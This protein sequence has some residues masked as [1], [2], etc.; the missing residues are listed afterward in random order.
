MGDERWRPLSVRRGIAEPDD[1][2]FEGVPDHLRGPLTAW[3][4][5]AI[6][7]WDTLPIEVAMRL[8]FSISTHDGETAADE[9][10]A[11]AAGNPDLFFDAV[12]ALLSIS[13][14][15]PGDGLADDTIQYLD[16]ILREGGSVWQVSPDQGALIQRVNPAVI[17]AVASVMS[18]AG[19]A[20]QH[21]AAAWRAAYGRH[22]DPPRAYSE[23][24]LA[25]EAAGGHLVLPRDSAATLGKM[26]NHIR[27]ALGRWHIGISLPADGGPDAA[28][29]LAM[30][31]LLWDGQSG[32]H[33]SGN[34]TGPVTQQ[35]AEMAVHLAATLVQW[36]TS[37]G[38]YK[39][40]ST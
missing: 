32:R 18:P 25:V 34:R 27:D 33:G 11:A 2:P 4:A 23:A 19:E 7:C 36:F 10:L 17:R 29:L 30:T 1:G 5:D 35:A 22:P 28:P 12:D 9:L 38:I 15:D 26:N 21:L 8:R 24:V 20:E 13:A 16:A 37:G 3:L 31:G 6:R 39:D 14:E 40:R